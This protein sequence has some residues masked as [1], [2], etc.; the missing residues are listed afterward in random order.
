MKSIVRA[1]LEREAYQVIEE[2]LSPPGERVSWESYRP[3][4]LGYRRVSDREEMVL[5]ECETRPNM[6]RL[7][8]KKHGTVTLQSFLFRE[9]SV[10]RILVVPQGKLSSVD[11]AVR[12]E[13]EVWVVGRRNLMG[14]AGTVTASRSGT[15]A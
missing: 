3:D 14:K 7:A 13:W 8:L 9:S 5:V 4:L 1:E 10:R 2:P 15:V 12:G 6:K 11:M